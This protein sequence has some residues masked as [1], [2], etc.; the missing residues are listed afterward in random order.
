MTPP[1]LPI[2]PTSLSP[3]KFLAPSQTLS[4]SLL[5]T[6]CALYSLAHQSQ[7]IQMTHLDKVWVDGF[8]AEQIWEQIWMLVGPFGEYFGDK[9]QEILENAEGDAEE[10]DVHVE[11]LEEDEE[12]DVSEHDEDEDVDNEDEEE[13]EGEEQD[14]ELEEN[15][16]EDM[17]SGSD[18]LDDDQVSNA[19]NPSDSPRKRKSIIDDEFF[20]LEDMERFADFGEARDMKRA[21]RNQEDLEE[22]DDEFA[23]EDELNEEDENAN[24][25]RYEDFFG[26]R[27]QHHERPDA[28]VRFSDQ[29][30]VKEFQREDENQEEQDQEDEDQGEENP[31]VHPS[32]TANLFDEDTQPDTTIS[33]FEREQKKLAAQ[34]TQLES[35][36]IAPKPWTLNG[37]AFSKSRPVNSLLEED[38]EYEHA[39]KPVPVITE[40]KTS[41][42]ED[43]IK[44]RIKDAVFD[45]V[46][47]KAPPRDRDFDPNRRIEIIEEKSSKGLAEVYEEDYMRKTGQTTTTEKDAALAAQHA[48]ID[49]LFKSLCQNLDALSNW[50]FQPKPTTVELQVT[51]LPNAPA[52][53]ME[54]ITP[55]H[56]ADSALVAPS[57]VFAPPKD[58]KGDKELSS[59]TKKRLRDKTRKQAGKARKEKQDRLQAIVAA[60]PR[61]AFAERKEKESALKKLMGQKNVTVVGKV[62][63]GAKARG[64]EKGGKIGER[65]VERA[66]FLRL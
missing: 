65:K 48:E 11:E 59:G 16:N 25:I 14:E 18:P 21:R 39:A 43:L 1:T 9:V 3:H 29:N 35:E 53:Q 26:P 60:K 47:R 55:S 10:S 61:T 51:P 62:D 44:Q 64:V 34:I 52:L 13:E 58:L 63:K 24:E 57:E 33:T 42:L 50:H 19:S 32:R 66:E 6:T 41:S 5:K 31:T 46:V 20:S 27:E 28:R 7:P 38:L 22:D 2:N 37:E 12:E 23:L 49:T 4:T 45:D 54:D 8:D 56:V 40:E 17:L 30:Q 36:A 15:D